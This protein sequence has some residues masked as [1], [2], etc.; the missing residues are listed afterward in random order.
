MTQ[1]VGLIDPYL[2]PISNSKLF[3]SRQSKTEVIPPILEKRANRP[4]NSNRAYIIA[5]Q[6]RSR[7]ANENSERKRANFPTN[8]NRG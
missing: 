5:R 7:S 2:L 4:T 8:S 1:I 6:S 3:H